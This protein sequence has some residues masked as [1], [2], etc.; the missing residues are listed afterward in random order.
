NVLSP[1]SQE[2]EPPALFSSS[3]FFP[4]SLPFLPIPSPADLQL[5]PSWMVSLVVVATPITG[6]CWYA[7]PASGSTTATSPTPFPCTVPSNALVFP[8]Q[9]LSSCLPTTS[10]ATRV[11]NFQQ[12][13]STTPRDCWTCMARMLRWIIGVMRLQWKIS[14]GC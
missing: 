12:P 4:A 9:T 8:T 3:S 11:T 14:S 2:H 1:C 13:C 10:L 5:P 7:P 6:P